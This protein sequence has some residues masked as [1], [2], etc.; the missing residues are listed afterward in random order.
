M[1]HSSYLLCTNH[2]KTYWDKTR[3]ERMVCPSS[4]M[5]GISVGSDSNVGRLSAGTGRSTEISGMFSGRLNAKLSW[6]HQPDYLH[7]APLTY[8]PQGCQV[9]YIEAQ[10]SSKQYGSQR[11]FKTQLQNTYNITFFHILS[12]NTVTRFKRRGQTLLLIGR[13]VKELRTF[14]LL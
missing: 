10:Y 1:S 5:S 8:Q 13:S 7:M 4:T 9:S 3:P 6:D 2:P 14:F 12:L 11:P